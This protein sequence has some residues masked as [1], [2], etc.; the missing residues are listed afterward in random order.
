M[1]LA[2]KSNGTFQ[3]TTALLKSDG[4]VVNVEWGQGGAPAEE[5]HPV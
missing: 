1:Q 2:V 3:T 4:V 5:T